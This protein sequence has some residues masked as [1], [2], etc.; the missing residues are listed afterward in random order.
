VAAGCLLFSAGV[1]I[2]LAIGSLSAANAGPAGS[3][4]T[5]QA[6]G[7]KAGTSATLTIRVRTTSGKLVKTLKGTTSADNAVLSWSFGCALPKGQY[8]VNAQVSGI[9]CT[10]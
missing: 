8:R 10:P 1:I 7:S 2:G 3:K 4:Q 5:V 6:A 9:V